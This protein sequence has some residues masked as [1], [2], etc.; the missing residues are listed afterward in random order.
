MK[1]YN[2]NDDFALNLRQILALAYAPLPDVNHAFETS[3]ETDFFVQNEDL[4]SPII[5]YFEDNWIGR[6]QC[7]RK[8]GRRPAKFAHS[9]WNVFDATNDEDPRTN[10]AI[11]GWH[12]RFNTLTGTHHQIC[13]S[14]SRL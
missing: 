3:K 8:G 13:G 4:L 7:I 9:L 12:H 5:D 11:E 10:N 1:Q 2:A 6:S 14:L